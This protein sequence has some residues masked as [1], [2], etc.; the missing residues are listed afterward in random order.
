MKRPD[1][2]HVGTMTPDVERAGIKDDK[3][4]ARMLADV[5]EET[6]IGWGPR[7]GELKI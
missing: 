5:P 3:R 2:L 7:A 6:G 1:E 4:A